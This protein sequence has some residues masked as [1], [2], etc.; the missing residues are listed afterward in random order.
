MSYGRNPGLNCGY[1][2]WSAGL[3]GIAEVAALDGCRERFSVC[4]IPSDARGRASGCN[5]QGSSPGGGLEDTPALQLET[6][7]Q[8][9]P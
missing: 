9:I 5:S 6:T 3:A 1:E 4:I 8:W 7:E 2:V